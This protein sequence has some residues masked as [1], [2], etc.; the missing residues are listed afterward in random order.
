VTPDSRL[1]K[2]A[3]RLRNKILLIQQNAIMRRLPRDLYGQ[4]IS[5][6]ARSSP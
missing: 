4:M 2:F 6:R 5:R 3:R 1:T